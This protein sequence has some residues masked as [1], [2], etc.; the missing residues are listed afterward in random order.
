MRAS[1]GQKKHLESERRTKKGRLRGQ[2]DSGEP[3]SAELSFKKINRALPGQFRLGFGIAAGRVVMKTMVHAVVYIGV[4]V[5]TIGFQSL[6][7]SRPRA[8]DS[9]VQGG[10]MQTQRVVVVVK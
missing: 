9:I 5:D 10:K 3:Y 6:F 7:I 8:I 2:L 4:I 1:G